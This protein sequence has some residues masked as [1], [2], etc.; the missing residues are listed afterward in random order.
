MTHPTPQTIKAAVH[1][2]RAAMQALFDQLRLGR[3]GATP[4][5]GGAHPGRR[6]SLGARK[7]DSEEQAVS[8]DTDRPAGH[9]DLAER[10]R[11]LDGTDLARLDAWWRA[12]CRNALASSP[13]RKS[14][15]TA[16]R[17]QPWNWNPCMNPDRG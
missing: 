9:H 14:S 2:Q 10:V 3:C 5:A 1:A 17:V 6:G 12:N 8:L 13:H 4:R 15:F 16:N 11:Q 7:T